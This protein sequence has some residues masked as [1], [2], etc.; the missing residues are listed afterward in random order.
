MPYLIVFRKISYSGDFALLGAFSHINRLQSSSLLFLEYAKRLIRVKF[1]NH[2]GAISRTM[3]S[4]LCTAGQVRIL[5]WPLFRR[6]A[7]CCLPQ[8]GIDVAWPDADLEDYR[9]PSS[10][11]RGSP[12]PPLCSI[13]WIETVCRH[14]ICMPHYMQ[15]ASQD[16]SVTNIGIGQLEEINRV[17]CNFLLH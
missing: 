7:Q 10:F 14:F 6:K 15:A 5:P 3:L 13:H 8:P 1:P 17:K 12:L 9:W 2:Y 4:A 11:E 16:A